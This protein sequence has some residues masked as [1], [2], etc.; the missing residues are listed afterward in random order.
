MEN[1]AAVTTR[2]ALI[3]EEEKDAGL[4]LEFWALQTLSPSLKDAPVSLAQLGMLKNP[5]ASA[6]LLPAS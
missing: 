3:R 6:Q 5:S 4:A 1:L 2:T